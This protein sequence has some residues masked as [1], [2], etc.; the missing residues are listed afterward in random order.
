[1]V[2]G[3]DLKVAVGQFSSLAFVLR[4]TTKKVVN[5]VRK[6]VHPRENSDYAYGASENRNAYSTG[7][8]LNR[9]MT[10]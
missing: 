5:F 2:G 1:L 3:G 4:A 10:F 9:L 8:L 7:C 6:K